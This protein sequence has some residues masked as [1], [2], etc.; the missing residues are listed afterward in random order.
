MV[1]MTNFFDLS[2]TAKRFRFIAFVEAVTWI[3]LLI[4]M[5]FKWIPTPTNDGAVRYP[6]MAHGAVFVLFLVMVIVA[7][8]EFKWEPKTIVLGLLAS[9]PPLGSVIFERWAVRTGRL[10]EL[11]VPTARVN[12]S[13]TNVPPVDGASG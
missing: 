2:S 5:G 13:T 1:G 9:I 12:A 11:S 3:A 10:G 6:G 8:R 7:A 4:S